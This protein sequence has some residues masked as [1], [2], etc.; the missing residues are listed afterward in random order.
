MR[1]LLDN[2]FGS[3]LMGVE[4]LGKIRCG[5]AVWVCT[6]TLGLKLFKSYSS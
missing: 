6:N 3:G 5:R 4:V 1:L 2:K